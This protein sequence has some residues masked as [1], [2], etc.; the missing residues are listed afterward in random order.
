MLTKRIDLSDDGRVYMDCYINQWTPLRPHMP[1]RPAVLICPGGA[2][3]VVSEREGEPVAL[4]YA[5]E[6]YNAFVLHYS[7]G[8]FA[9]F[10]NSAVDAARAIALIRENADKWNIDPEKI[11]L[12]GFSA[13]GHITATLGTLWNT[14]EF[15]VAANG[16]DIRP[17]ALILGYPCISADIDAM[18]DMMGLLEAGRGADYIKEAA[19]CEKHVSENTPPAFIFSSFEDKLL[20]VEHSLL[21]ANAMAK[22]DRRFQLHIFSSGKHGCSLS[23][24]ATALGDE[25]YYNASVEEWFGLS[26]K[27]LEEVFGPTLLGVKYVS[28]LKP[29]A[30][31][32][33]HIGQ[34]SMSEGV[35]DAMT[36]RAGETKRYSLS[37]RLG[38]VLEN[39]E[40][41]A[42]LRDC[43]PDCMGILDNMQAADYEKNLELPVQ[44]LVLSGGLSDDAAKNL[45]ARL[46]DIKR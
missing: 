1:K 15:K 46:R 30:T 19:S 29:T 45:S 39:A 13:G 7:I 14:D 41:E 18:Q 40:A 6:G 43:V 44:Y 9:A 4:A 32:R 33:A 16:A 22:N 35:F 28:M 12:C 24:G 42:V 23:W 17:N 5:A 34:P 8:L 2:Y 20:P 10:P 27:W 11:A 3:V 31:L 37:T 26:I 36:T 38:D 25:E 21:F